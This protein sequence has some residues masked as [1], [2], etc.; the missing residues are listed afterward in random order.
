MCSAHDLVAQRG[1]RDALK[2]EDVRSEAEVQT[3][4]ACT[5]VGGDMGS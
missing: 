5:A 4:A 3:C 2:Q 1:I